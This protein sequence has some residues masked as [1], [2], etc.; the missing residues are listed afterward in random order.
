MRS[1][2]P[3]SIGGGPAASIATCLGDVDSRTTSESTESVQCIKK[4]RVSAGA[5]AEASNTTPVQKQERLSSRGARWSGVSSPSTGRAARH[6][7][8]QVLAV[9]LF[10]P[11]RLAAARTAQLYGQS[12]TAAIAKRM[13]KERMELPS[14]EGQI[15]LLTLRGSGLTY[16]P[17][18]IREEFHIL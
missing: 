12:S 16:N 1:R 14:D 3:P 6:R 8:Q 11:T 9:T 18:V 15:L 7:S 4:R 10:T 17:N 5:R 2:R 13:G